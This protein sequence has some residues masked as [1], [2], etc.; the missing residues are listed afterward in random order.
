MKKWPKKLL[1]G[2]A[3]IPM[4]LGL[5]ACSKEK[6]VEV[7]KIVTEYVTN[8]GQYEG[9][10]N[11]YIGA[12]ATLPVDIANARAVTAMLPDNVKDILNEVIAYGEIMK[13]SVP[14]I[15]Q[16]K[17]F[18]TE[19]DSKVAAAEADCAADNLLLE[20]L[21]DY[22]S[23]YGSEDGYSHDE[24]DNWFTV[25]MGF[26]F[27]DADDENHWVNFQYNFERDDVNLSI[28]NLQ[29]NLHNFESRTLTEGEADIAL[30]ELLGQIDAAAGG[31]GV[32]LPADFMDFTVAQLRAWLEGGALDGKVDGD[33]M[34]YLF[35]E[36]VV[37][38][39]KVFTRGSCE[40]RNDDYT[41]QC[42]LASGQ[43]QETF[44][45]AG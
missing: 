36:L 27:T 25:R 2:V 29:I 38:E 6:I 34:D 26:G 37:I 18:L 10:V 21:D 40:I 30:G 15:A 9:V 42:R 32:T 5:A 28:D 31:L 16:T 1:V 11:G 7:E 33:S 3:V 19:L 14:T 35:G 41:V 24:G 43:K 45:F 12:K 44:T 8:Y 13:N 17:A 39:T 20:D 4:A 23:N 22:N